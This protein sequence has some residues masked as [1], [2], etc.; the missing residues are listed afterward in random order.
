MAW[1]KIKEGDGRAEAQPERG[2]QG[3]PA[4][5]DRRGHPTEWSFRA[6]GE[7]APGGGGGGRQHLGARTA[8]GAASRDLAPPDPFP[9]WSDRWEGASCRAAWPSLCRE[10]PSEKRQARESDG[11]WRGWKLFA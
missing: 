5:R 3:V 2:T 7:N 8:V 1:K 11:P 10:G 9:L 4:G 6:A